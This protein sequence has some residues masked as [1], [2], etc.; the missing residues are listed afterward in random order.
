MCFQLLTRKLLSDWRQSWFF[1]S[2]EATTACPG[3]QPHGSCRIPIP[4]L[5]EHPIATILPP[6][7]TRPTKIQQAGKPHC[8]PSSQSGM[9]ASSIC[10]EPHCVMLPSAAR[11]LIKQQQRGANDLQMNTSTSVHQKAASLG[12]Q[13][14]GTLPFLKRVL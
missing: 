10:S 14:G 7:A 2:P 5:G 4:G 9:Q 1:K 3:L 13:D 12:S 8:S 11:K 6:L